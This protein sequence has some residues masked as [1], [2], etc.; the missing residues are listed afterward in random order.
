MRLRKILALEKPRDMNLKQTK[1]QVSIGSRE[2]YHA[3]K[4][5]NHLGT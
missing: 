5:K 2:S 3:L 1:N 4:F